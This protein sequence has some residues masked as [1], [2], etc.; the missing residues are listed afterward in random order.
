MA[1]IKGLMLNLIKKLLMMPWLPMHP[2]SAPPGAAEL[3]G[4]LV[5]AVQQSTP[6][7]A[8]LGQ[9]RSWAEAAQAGH[10]AQSCSG[11]KALH[12][13]RRRWDRLPSCCSGAIFGKW[14]ISAPQAGTAAL[15]P[16][17]AYPELP[18]TPSPCPGRR[19]SPPPPRRLLLC[20]WLCCQPPLPMQHW[21]YPHQSC[22][23][24]RS[25]RS[26]LFL[27]SLEPGTP[28]VMPSP[29]PPPAWHWV[30]WELQGVQ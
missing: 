8:P 24:P 6:S 30:Y 9:G 12:A 17:E 26:S 16:G 7:P 23:G 19:Q 14:V 25:C 20:Q 10:A 22:S 2:S 11:A 28:T 29:A 4:P 18:T 21:L 5:S 13:G 1:S 15:K 3:A 27:P